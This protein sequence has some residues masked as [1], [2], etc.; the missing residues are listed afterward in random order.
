MGVKTVVGSAICAAAVLFASSSALPVLAQ[1]QAETLAWITYWTIEPHSSAK[2]EEAIK[3]HNAFHKAQND[4]NAALTWEILTGKMT[5][6]YMRG[7]V[8]RQWADFDAPGVDEVADAADVAATIGP[9][10]ARAKT[11]VY[12]FWPDLSRLPEGGP[13]KLARIVHFNIKRGSQ[14]RLKEAIGRAHE[15]I[16]KSNWPTTYAW[17]E[18]VD[19]GHRPTFA[20]VLPKENWAGFASPEKTFDKMLTEVYGAEEAGKI[21][22]A[23]GESIEDESSFTIGQRLDLSYLPATE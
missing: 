2:F 18:V 8:G 5:G 9:H 14:G 21:L 15:A 17:Y 1:E 4:P 13:S 19:G 23:F 20:L 11:V 16:G 12:E 7:A 3:K 10:I 6:H 22:S